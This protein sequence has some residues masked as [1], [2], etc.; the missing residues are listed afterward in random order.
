MCVRAVHVFF[1]FVIKC[2]FLN[3]EECS[4]LSGKTGTISLSAETKKNKYH[5]K[6][7][8]KIR[9]TPE[10]GPCILYQKD[11]PLHLFHTIR[12]CPY[13]FAGLRRIRVKD[14]HLL[15]ALRHHRTGPIQLAFSHCNGRSAASARRHAAHVV[16]YARALG[17]PSIFADFFGDYWPHTRPVSQPVPA[18]VYPETEEN[19]Q[20]AP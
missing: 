17:L 4:F 10:I 1:D 7:E 19:M 8:S 13:I 16:L 18:H 11:R 6:G 2:V 20:I 12:T 14:P 3:H 15:S 9:Q 5:S